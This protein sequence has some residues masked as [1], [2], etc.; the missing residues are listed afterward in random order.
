MKLIPRSRTAITPP[1]ESYSPQ[2]KGSDP[3]PADTMHEAQL[4]R[5]SF[6]STFGHVRHTLQLDPGA[7]A[8]PPLGYSCRYRAVLALD[9]W[10]NDG[11]GKATHPRTRDR[12]GRHE[13]GVGSDYPDAGMSSDRHSAK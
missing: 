2:A 12:S 7:M 1:I 5:A 10:P 11:S 13:V 6:E 9:G 3:A 4:E 8:Q